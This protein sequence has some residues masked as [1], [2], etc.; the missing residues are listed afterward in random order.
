MKRIIFILTIILTSNFITMGQSET[1]ILNP[2]YSHQS[3]YSMANGEVASVDNT[4]WDIAF[5]LSA[6]G[7]TIRINGQTGTELY[8]YENGDISDWSVLDTTGLYMSDPMYNSDT[9]WFDGA[10]DKNQTANPFD[11]G[12]GVYNTLTHAVEGD[13]LFVVKLADNSWKKIEISSLIGGVY[14]FKYADLDGANEVLATVNKAD[15]SNKNFVY[16]SLQ[17]QIAI[18]REPDNNAWDIVFTR[19]V[20]E[21]SPGVYY[22]VTGVLQNATRVAS[23]A[24]SIPDPSTYTDYASHPFQ[25]EINTIGY[26]WK[27]FDFN[28]FSYAIDPNTCFFIE[29]A[30]LDVWRIVFDSFVGSS[31]GELTFN[32]FLIDEVTLYGCTDFNASNYNPLAEEDDGSCEFEGCTDPMFIEFDPYA[33]TDDGSCSTLIVSGCIY[34]FADN[35]NILA[36]LDDGSCVY[37]DTSCKGDFDNDGAVTVSDLTGFLAAFGEL[38]D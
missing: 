17:N 22:G 6:Q 20:G 3:Y 25:A 21:L 13:S 28:S 9:D 2:G 5:D 32:K 7:S 37:T 23:E 15:Y 24:N 12:W 31:T 26:D 36:N 8:T 29:D 1:I 34:D 33:T 14:S 18:D 30:T 27:V 4:N 16:Y 11:L 10:F 19:Y 38:C 35:Y